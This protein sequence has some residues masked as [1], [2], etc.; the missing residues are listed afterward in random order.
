[1]AFYRRT[2][3]FLMVL[4]F[5]GLCAANPIEIPFWHSHAG[6][7]GEE[8]SYLAKGFN[9]SQ[10]KFRVR[11]IYKGDY[12]ECLTNLAAAFRAG[13]APP[14]VQIFEVGFQTMVNPQGIIKPIDALSETF[15]FRLPVDSFF[16]STQSFYSQEGKL[17][18][19]PFNTS[20]PV[21][22]YNKEALKKVGTDETNFPKT[23]D[24]FETLASKLRAAGYPCAYTTANPAWIF[25]ESFSA[26]HGLPV[27]S[28]KESKAVFN[29]PKQVEFLK[30]I[31]LWQK[32][33]YFEYGGRT[34]DSSI[35][36][37][38]G[39][40]PLYSQ[41]SGAYHSLKEM[42]SFSLGVASI[43]YDPNLSASR[44]GNVTGGGA[45]WVIEGHTHETY[46][47]VAEFVQ[48]LARPDVQ[49]HFHQ[50]T[51]YLPLGG[52][53]LYAHITQDNALPTLALAQSELSLDKQP[54]EAV[55][56][57]L[58]NA[59]RVINEESLEAIFSGM[60]SPQKAMDDAVRRSNHAMMRLNKNTTRTNQI[61]DK[62]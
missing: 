11:P 43:P 19:M 59:V 4:I 5:R 32:K 1:M 45:L 55:T 57:R 51:G 18:A 10:S 38:S 47:G 34:D 20:I 8:V 25:I 42:T 29:N 44:H 53:G 24:D 35:L 14:L 37:T 58:F 16:S 12:N 15:G 2:F 62:I 49:A 41:S 23:W 13:L 40:C 36:F 39:R 21:M 54:N 6:L 31:Q 48:Y 28:H 30:R 52:Q 22:F 27:I 7:L 17:L 61:H 46:E 3:F 50:N 26:I 56:N 9:Q 60:K 33:H